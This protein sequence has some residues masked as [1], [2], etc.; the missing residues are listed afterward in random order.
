MVKTFR[1]DKFLFFLFSIFFVTTIG[2]QENDSRNSKVELIDKKIIYAQNENIILSNNM[3]EIILKT[4]HSDIRSMIN[5][6]QLNQDCTEIK[7]TII[8][9]EIFELIITL[10]KN[11]NKKKLLQFMNKQSEIYNCDKKGILKMFFHISFGLIQ[12]K[13]KVKAEPIKLE[14]YETLRSFIQTTF[15]AACAVANAVT[16]NQFLDC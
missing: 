11:K 10:I 3:I 5:F 6:L 14:N 13:Q 8:T 9:D 15:G 16:N 2:C 12:K 4:Y 7:D 1:S